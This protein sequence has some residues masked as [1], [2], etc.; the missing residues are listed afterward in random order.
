MEI[1][2][3]IV[4]Y[5]I[6]LRGP[7]TGYCGNVGPRRSLRGSAIAPGGK[8]NGQAFAVRE[9]SRGGAAGEVG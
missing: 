4:E 2:K 1:A 9:Q 6:G 3:S 7:G 8:E 5:S